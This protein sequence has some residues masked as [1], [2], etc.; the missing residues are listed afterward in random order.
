VGSAVAAFLARHG[1]AGAA[2]LRH[3]ARESRFMAAVVSNLEMVLAKADPVIA[4]RY[5]KLVPDGELRTRVFGAIEAEAFRAGVPR[6][7]GAA[8]F[9]RSR[10][11]DP[12]GPSGRAFPG[13][14]LLAAQCEVAVGG[15]GDRGFQK[16]AR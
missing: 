1:D 8:D 11:R 9:Q 6:S 15:T 3:L 13:G 5:S 14:D 4:R 7:R 16:A 2:R 10:I 12:Q